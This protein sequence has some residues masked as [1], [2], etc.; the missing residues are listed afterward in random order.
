MIAQIPRSTL[1][2]R[3]EL[4]EKKKSFSD[5]SEYLNNEH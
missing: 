2:S 1:N 3:E 4:E 5:I